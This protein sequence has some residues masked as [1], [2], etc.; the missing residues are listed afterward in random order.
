[1]QDTIYN[2][3]VMMHTPCTV[4]NAAGN[5]DDADADAVPAKLDAE[6]VGARLHYWS[7]HVDLH[8]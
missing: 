8:K 6:E 4:S 7:Y 1:M 2:I 5:T 3:I